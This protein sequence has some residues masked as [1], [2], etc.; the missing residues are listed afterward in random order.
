MD[1]LQEA[2][3][4]EPKE[5]RERIYENAQKQ[6]IAAITA[7]MSDDSNPFKMKAY[8][9]Y[10]TQNKVVYKFNECKTL[11]HDSEQYRPLANRPERNL[12]GSRSGDRSWFS[13]IIICTLNSETL[14]LDEIE[15]KG[16][17]LPGCFLNREEANA[18]L[19]EVT[20]YD[21]FEGGMAAVSRRHVYE[22]TPFKLLKVELTLNTGEE[23]VL[24]VERCLVNLDRDLTKRERGL[25]KWSATRP[26]LQ[27]YIV[28]CEFMTRKTTESSLHELDLEEEEQEQDAPEGE[29]SATPSSTPSSRDLN[30]AATTKGYSSSGDSDIELERLPLA[31]FTD[32]ELANEHAGNL[33]LRHSAVS[34]AIRG[35]LDDFWWVNNAVPVHRDAERAVAAKGNDDALYAADLYT[36]DMK[37]RLGFDWMRV[38]VYAVDDVTGPLN[39]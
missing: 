5:I 6:Y 28:E 38:A 23:R 35:P 8:Y 31:T 14:S 15:E 16:T 2:L 29:S 12:G 7:A 36:F 11:T 22:D 27:H 3:K 17:K 24:W 39:I 4:A 26:K 20:Q 9:K 32:R 34:R 18:K 1:C 13:Y 37:A 19:D 10:Q 21:K 33:F 25:K 30:A